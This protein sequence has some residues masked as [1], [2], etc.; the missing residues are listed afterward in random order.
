MLLNDAFEFGKIN[1]NITTNFN[2]CGI[3]FKRFNIYFYY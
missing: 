3:K 1:N 2:D